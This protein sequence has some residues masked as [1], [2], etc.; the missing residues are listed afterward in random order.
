MDE[1]AQVLGRP[2]STVLAQLLELEL[3]SLVN[4]LPGKKFVRA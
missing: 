2:V 1:I 3:K 4:Q